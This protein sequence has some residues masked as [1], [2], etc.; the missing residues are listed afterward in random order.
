MGVRDYVDVLRRQS[1]PVALT[2]LLTVLA[3]LVLFLASPPS[4][5]SSVT[6]FMTGTLP[7]SDQLTAAQADELAQSRMPSYA[8]LVTS[9]TMAVKVRRGLELAEPLS[10]VQR[11]ITAKVPDD[12]VLLQVSATARTAEEAFDKARVIA[13]EFPRTVSSLEPSSVKIIEPAYRPGSRSAPS[14]QRFVILTLLAGLVLAFAVAVGRE[15]MST[16]IRGAADLRAAFATPEGGVRRSLEPGIV[17]DQ[18]LRAFLLAVRRQQPRP[19]SVSLVSAESG[20]TSSWAAARLADEA[21]SLGWRT[22]LIDADLTAHGITSGLDLAARPGLT[23]LLKDASGATTIAL[24]DEDPVVLGVGT[25]VE[26]RN[27]RTSTSGAGT[28]A[29]PKPG[30]LEVLLE[31]FLEDFDLVVI[32]SG[33]LSPN[34]DAVWSAVHADV[35]LLAAAERRDRRADV[36]AAFDKMHDLGLPVSTIVLTRGS[37]TGTTD[38]RG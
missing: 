17:P 15:M 8:A 22:L 20:G 2:L 12:T 35:V 1:R 23:D 38:P 30:D 31:R 29:S 7:G 37:A 24:S 16:T 5:R 25:V 27:W 28:Q 19:R 10:E 3:G 9:R 32:D 14:P 18:D 33:G 26:Q 36:V 21:Q 6:F 34:L 4:Y 13:T 11:S